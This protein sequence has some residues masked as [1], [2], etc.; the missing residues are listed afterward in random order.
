MRDLVAIPFK[1]IKTGAYAPQYSQRGDAA[2]DLRICEP[3]TVMP[4]EL[5]LVKLGI[6]IELPPG[7][8]AKIIGRSG[9]TLKGFTV[10]PGLIDETYRGEIGILCYNRLGTEFSFETGARIAQML[11]EQTNLV[12]F[13]EVTEL[14]KTERGEHGFGSSGV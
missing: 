10:L 11:V 9:L 7:Y 3:V 8:C 12:S 5:K 4:G 1:K 13:H 2:L 14:T 6:A